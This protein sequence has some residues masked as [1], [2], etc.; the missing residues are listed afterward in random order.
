VRGR[1]GTSPLA[2]GEKSSSRSRW[3]NARLSKPRRPATAE[4]TV[5]PVPAVGLS[6]IVSHCIFGMELGLEDQA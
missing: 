4:A 5:P 1:L 2:S 6:V 3:T